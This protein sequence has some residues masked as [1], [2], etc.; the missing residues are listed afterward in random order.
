MVSREQDWTHYHPVSRARERERGI[1][2]KEMEEE[3]EG[4]S[5]LLFLK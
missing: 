4:W 2:K 5:E 1:G 3:K